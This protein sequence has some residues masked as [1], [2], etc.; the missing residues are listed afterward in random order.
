MILQFIKTKIGVSTII[1]LLLIIGAVGIKIAEKSNKEASLQEKVGLIATAS[2]KNAL[3]REDTNLE[4]A[5]KLIESSSTPSVTVIDGS[6]P[7]AVSANDGLTAT[8][9][10]ARDIFTKYV[11]AKKSGGAIDA[12]TAQNI[13]DSVLNS[14]YSGD[15]ILI[16]SKDLKITTDTSIA[17][18]KVYG[19]QVGKALSIPKTAGDQEMIIL[20]RSME[21]GLT[22]ADARALGLIYA[23]YMAMIKGLTE[24]TVPAA[25]AAAH[26]DMI[27][28]LGYVADAVD[29]I[30]RLTS[31]PIGSLTKIKFYEE[32]INLM[33]GSSVKFKAFFASKNIV[34]SSTEAG[35]G[36]T[37]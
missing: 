28:G 2:V 26:A 32:G 10:F 20:G 36:L 12:A 3:N 31:D 11:E 23:R 14:D 35:Y 21:N 34:F 7:K 30:L 13:A 17:R 4:D 9:R 22:E 15:K 6:Q 19:N 24:I 33:I 16:S 18:A 27:N 37:Q 25:A 5:L 29:G 8:D 1:A